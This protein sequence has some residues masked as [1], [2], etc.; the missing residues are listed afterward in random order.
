MAQATIEIDG[1]LNVWKSNCPL[2]G[3]ECQHLIP[4]AKDDYEKVHMICTNHGVDTDNEPL[5]FNF[6]AIKTGE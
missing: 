4:T 2:C 1:N 6:I 3:V 5:T